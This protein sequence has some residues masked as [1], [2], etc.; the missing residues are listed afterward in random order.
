MA[1]LIRGTK[2]DMLALCQNFRAVQKPKL[3]DAERE[4]LKRL[5][6][7]KDA[8]TLKEVRILI[9]EKFN[10]EYSEMQVGEC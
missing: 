2:V 8:W 4:E 7:E 1:G 10:V 5:L 9:K 3:G 6:G